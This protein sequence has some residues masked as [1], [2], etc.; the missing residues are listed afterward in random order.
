MPKRAL[1]ILGSAFVLA[2]A[3]FPGAFAQDQEPAEAAPAGPSP[4]AGPDEPKKDNCTMDEKTGKEV[5]GNESKPGTLPG[6]AKAAI[7]IVTITVVFLIL[8]TIFYIRRSRRAAAEADKE[9]A[10]DESQMTGPPAV[11]HA[12]Y[13]PET[14]HSR[15]YSIGPDSG[16]ISAS[17]PVPLTPAVGPIGQAPM[18][19]QPLPPPSANIGGTPAFPSP[20]PSVFSRWGSSSGA[21]QPQTAPANKANFEANSYPFAGFGSTNGNNPPNSA[22]RKLLSRM[23]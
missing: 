10:I 22:V 13:T 3:S 2:L 18:F 16:A 5:C 15:V 6:S 8:A 11:L 23:G 20:R 19:N 7:V 4:S 14:G 9:V 21:S 12:T 17:V 1:V